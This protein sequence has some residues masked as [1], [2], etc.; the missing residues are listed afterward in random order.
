MARIRT[1]KPE[2]FDD[3]EV[4]AMSFPARLAF[5]GLWGHADREGRMKDRPIRL[6]ARILPFDDVDMDGLLDEMARHGFIQRYV[7][8]GV[9]L[10]QVRTLTRHQQLSPREPESTLPPPPEE[11]HSPG[12]AQVVLEQGSVS[13]GKGREGNGKGNGTDVL[14]TPSASDVVSL[15]NQS[16]ATAVQVTKPS[17]QDVV[18]LWNQL[19]TPPIPQVTKLTADRRS[20]IDARLKT[21]PDLATW[22]TVIA[23][24]NGQEWCRA[25]GTGD[26]PNW[27]ATL[28]WL[29]RNDGTLARYVERAA[30]PV[31]TVPRQP[32]VG[33]DARWSPSECWHTP[34]CATHEQH[35]A[36]ARDDIAASIARKAQRPA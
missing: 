30:T 17:A 23:W 5:I 1:I 19:V 10:I 26:H 27:T 20:K 29:C 11:K 2:F 28:D 16:D 35:K 21:Y 6:K 24:L 4:A 31:P 36:K 12:H 15:R 14:R 3:E 25:P 7:A 33:P 32:R 18:R 22:R 8:G 34:Q 9:N 13:A